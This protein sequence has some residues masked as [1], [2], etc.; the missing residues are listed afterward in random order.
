MSVQARCRGDGVG[1]VD[2][3]VPHIGRGDPRGEAHAQGQVGARVGIVQ[4]FLQGNAAFRVQLV[5]RLVKGAHANLGA[6]AHRLLDRRK[7]AFG[8]EVRDVGGVEHHF[9]G[10]NQLFVQTRNQPLRHH[11]RQVQAEVDEQLVVRIFR[12]EVITRSIAWLALLACS[13]DRHRW[14]VSA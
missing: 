13:V 4:S 6:V 1:R 8:D 11:P 9:H 7:L 5:Q 10:G 12:E 3:Q 2:G 14:P